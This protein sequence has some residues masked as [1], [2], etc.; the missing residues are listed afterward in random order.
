[1]IRTNLVAFAAL[2]ITILVGIAALLAHQGAVVAQSHSAIRSFPA[3]RAAPGSEVEISI[4]TSNLGGFGQVEE[5][6]P[7]GFTFVRSSLDVF[8]VRVTGQTVLFTLI[9]GN[10]FT[11]VATAPAM[12]GQ[13]T[14][15]GIVRNSDRV[16]QAI[17]GRTTLRIEPEP[18]PV[19]TSAPAPQPPPRPRPTPQPT[20]TPTPQPTPTP[21]PQPTP[22][23]TPQPTPTPTPQPTP[24]PTPQPTPTPTPQPT[25]TPMPQPTPTSTP[26]PTPTSTPQPT[27]T[28][29]M[30]P[31]ATATPTM[32]PTATATSTPEPTATPTPEPTTTPTPEPTAMPTREPTATLTPE[33]I[34]S[35]PEESD[36]VGI[37]PNW[38]LALLIGL[39]L[40]GFIG[41]LIIIRLRRA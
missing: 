19:P 21:T 8:Q 18:T 40:V 38:L 20:P 29:T 17:E 25:P 15:S 7:E 11:Y 12:E 5:T 39:A 2:A 16:E 24:T 14:F 9:S 35:Q 26:Q 34:P 31:T 27:A 1:M 6:L 23:P 36:S 3:D 22:T 41:S 30:E 33:P 32:E 13:Y 28:P 37:F 4:T 10:R